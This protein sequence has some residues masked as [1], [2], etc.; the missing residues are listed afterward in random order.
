MHLRTPRLHPG[1]QTDLYHPDAAYVAWQAGHNGLTTFDLYTRSSRHRDGSSG[2]D[3][4]F[5]LG[6]RGF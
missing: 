1:L 4:D 6:R 2:L 3:R 5:F